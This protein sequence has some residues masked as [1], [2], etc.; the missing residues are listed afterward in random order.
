MYIVRLRGELTAMATPSI[1]IAAM[2][3]K[4]LAELARQVRRLTEEEHELVEE[5]L[6]AEP[7]IVGSVSNVLRRCGNPKLPLRR[8]PLSTRRTPGDHA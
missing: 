4:T 8:A 1:L 2:N 3:V 7:L 6:T 5:L